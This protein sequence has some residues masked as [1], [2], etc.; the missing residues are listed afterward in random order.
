MHNRVLRAAALC[1]LLMW[2]GVPG[3]AH[4][5]DGLTTTGQALLDQSVE[6]I[7]N[8]L[9]AEERCLLRDGTLVVVEIAENIA[10]DRI[11]R[12]DAY[13]LRLAHPLQVGHSVIPAGTNGMGEVIH[14]EASRG[15]GKAGELLLAA[16]YLQHG[17][18]LIGLRAMKFARSGADTS[19]ASL[20]TSIAAAS[21]NPA[22][23]FLGMFI[24][25]REVNVAEGALAV[26]KVNGDIVLEACNQPPVPSGQ[27]L[28]LRAT[29]GSQQQQATAS[30]DQPL[31][32]P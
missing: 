32:Q 30:Q 22:A 10:S 23:A 12:G 17:Q 19:P 7:E 27:P 5:D 31:Q 2:L 29:T 20:G 16:R 24:H 15:G 11:K 26:A 21:I 3:T 13:P 6:P 8:P 28:P 1:G 9:A 14:A 18:Q 25:G 4:T